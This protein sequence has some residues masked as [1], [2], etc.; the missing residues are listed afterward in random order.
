MKW[1]SVYDQLPMSES[2]MKMDYHE[3]DI[4]VFDGD[5][6]PA[7]FACGRCGGFWSSFDVDGQLVTSS[8]THWMKYPDAPKE[9]DND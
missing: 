8:V 6:K 5:V 2:D 3:C 7:I 4:I 1:I 9:F